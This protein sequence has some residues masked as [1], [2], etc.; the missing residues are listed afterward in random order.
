M[1]VKKSCDASLNK[2]FLHRVALFLAVAKYVFMLFLD[3]CLLRQTLRE[4]WRCKERS[5]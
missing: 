3:G 1:M 2:Q 4:H 5:W